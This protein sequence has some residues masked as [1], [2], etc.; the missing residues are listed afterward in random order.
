MD[1]DPSIEKSIIQPLSGPPLIQIQ[2]GSDATLPITVCFVLLLFID[3][4]KQA[5]SSPFQN[6]I[7]VNN[8]R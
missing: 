6:I 1:Y 7:S 3:T 4:Q 8:P 2:Y 5:V